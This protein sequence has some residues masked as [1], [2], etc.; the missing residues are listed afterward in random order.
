MSARAGS[1]V[2]LSRRLHSSLTHEARAITTGLKD[3]SGFREYHK[4][5]RSISDEGS[6][7]TD[8]W[9]LDDCYSRFLLI[10]SLAYWSGYSF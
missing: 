1:L 10:A 8:V 9:T 7:K 3:I 2:R 5:V 6:W 4:N